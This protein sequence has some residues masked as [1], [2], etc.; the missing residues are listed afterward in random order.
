ME[1]DGKTLPAHTFIG[2]GWSSILLWDCGNDDSS[3]LIHWS[4]PVSH[5]TFRDML[6][7]SVGSSP[8]HI[9]A[10]ALFF[11]A[12]CTQSLFDHLMFVGE[13]SIPGQAIDPKIIF[14]GSVLNLGTVTDSVSV[15]NTQM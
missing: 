13:G 11:E 12:D 3:H 1:A 4:S 5:L 15:T 6:V 10:Y 8:K 14:L 9:N 2:D 7:A